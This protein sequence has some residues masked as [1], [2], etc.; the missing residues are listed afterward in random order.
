MSTPNQ[1]RGGQIAT[2]GLLVQI[3][4]ALLDITK[5]EKPFIEITLEPNVGDDQFDFLWTDADGAH[6]VQ[7]KSTENIFY[8]KTVED[9]ANKLQQAGTNESYRLVLVGNIHP[10]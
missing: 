2:R 9:W 8:K 3:L 5:A 10:D 7:V 4:V 1:T 6:A